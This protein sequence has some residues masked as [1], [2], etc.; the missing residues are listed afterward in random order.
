MQTSN[1][2][3]NEPEVSE[4][5]QAETE[6]TDLQS[7]PEMR[8]QLVP[9]EP[10]VLDYDYHHAVELTKQD[11]WYGVCF[12]LIFLLVCAGLGLWVMQNSVNAYYQQTY[13]E[14]SP[15]TVL[16]DSPLWKQGGQIGTLLYA[17]HDA[18][19]QHIGEFNQRITDQFNAD[20]AYTPAYKAQLAET[21][22]LEKI[23]L[24]KEA[25]EKA[26][27]NLINQFTLTQQD[28]VFFAGDSMMQGIAPHV[29]KSLLENHQIKTVNLSKQ[30]TGLAYPGFFDWPK[31]IAETIAANPQIK[32]LVVFLGPNDPWDMPNPKGGTYLKFKSPEWEAVYRS[33]IANIIQ[34]AQAHHVNV[35]WISPPNMKKDSLNAQ[36]VYLNGVIANEVQKN[37][38]FSIDSRKILGQVNNVYS[39]YLLKD[40]QSIKMRSADG[41]HFSTEGQKVIADEVLQYL[42]VI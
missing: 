18:I 1:Q 33:R 35:M 17:Q 15:L 36:M 12:G 20:Y 24:A 9:D 10:T 2:K 41:I 26:K 37:H 32:V 6:T 21:A 11:H 19:A 42:R 38:A 40:G 31:T 22:R 16:N 27:N 13:H 39:D 29:Q 34:T 4:S 25:A 14:D 23:R 30:S 8:P 28:Q 5:L 3:L 7:V